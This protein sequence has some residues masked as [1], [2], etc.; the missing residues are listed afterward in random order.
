MTIIIYA[1]KLLILKGSR[2][3]S[4]KKLWNKFLVTIANGITTLLCGKNP[5]IGIKLNTCYVM[6][7]YMDFSH[8]AMLY[9]GLRSSE[10]YMI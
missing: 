5:Y 8:R 2:D 1:S 6:P 7:M 4:D 3:L 10:P 9:S